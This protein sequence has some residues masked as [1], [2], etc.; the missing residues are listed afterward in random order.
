MACCGC[1]TSRAQAQ[2]DLSSVMST[3]CDNDGSCGVCCARCAGE[4][5]Q[6]PDGLLWVMTDYRD[7]WPS[8]PDGMATSDAPVC[9]PCARTTARLCPGLRGRMVLVRSKTHPVV[10]VQGVRYAPTP[11]G[12]V[13]VESITVAFDD[14]VIRWTVAHQL[15]R[16]LHDCVIVGSSVD[17]L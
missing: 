8:W 12:L 9:A 16:Q 11:Q 13:A 10:G 17:R 14:P 7:D 2:E 5:D 15:V 1:G 4:P 3:R 6:N